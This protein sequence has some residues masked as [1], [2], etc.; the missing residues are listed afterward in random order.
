MSSWSN[1]RSRKISLSKKKSVKRFQVLY[2]SVTGVSV[3][4]RG[5]GPIEVLSKV[6]TIEAVTVYFEALTN[7]VRVI[8]RKVEN[9]GLVLTNPAAAQKFQMEFEASANNA[10]M[11]TLKGK[12][13]SLEEFNQLKSIKAIQ[14]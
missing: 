10:G 12:G 8:A 2:E 1:R 14:M 4:R 9:E 11:E 5:Q 3:P 6:E 7:M 13:V